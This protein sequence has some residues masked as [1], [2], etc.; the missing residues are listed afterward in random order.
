MFKFIS[1]TIL[2]FMLLAATTG[3]AVSKHF[4]NGFLISSSIYSEAE[5]CCDRD[6]CQDQS[7]F[8]QLDEKYQVSESAGLPAI[9]ELGLLFAT[10]WQSDFL[11]G[12]E[13]VQFLKPEN[14][15]PPSGMQTRLSLRQAYLL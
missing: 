11:L 5:K 6:C 15:P 8:V 10:S 14:E 4:C 3:M 2:Y 7:E 9:T 1:H 13:Y 12:D